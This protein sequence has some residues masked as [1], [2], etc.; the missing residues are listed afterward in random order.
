MIFEVCQTKR[1]TFDDLFYLFV[2]LFVFVVK[3][4]H[5]NKSSFFIKL[6]FLI[7]KS[8]LNIFLY[9]IFPLRQNIN[10]SIDS[11]ANHVIGNELAYDFLETFQ[12]FL[13][14]ITG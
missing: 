10:I 12:N 3:T 13:L 4:H 7:L 8:I 2:V 6:H 11:I 1:G 14:N 9:E 5:F